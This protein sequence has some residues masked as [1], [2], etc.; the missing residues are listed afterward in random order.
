MFTPEWNASF[1]LGCEDQW[2]DDE[3]PFIIGNELPQGDY[4]GG[5][6]GGIGPLDI[7]DG[8][9]VA[10]QFSD[11]DGPGPKYT[12]EHERAFF[13]LSGL[14]RENA[15]VLAWQGIRDLA[16]TIGALDFDSSKA[17]SFG[18]FLLVYE[19]AFLI[20]YEQVFLLGGGLQ[21][22]S[23]VPSRQYDLI[24]ILVA[25]TDEPRA[26]TK[27]EGRRDRAKTKQTAKENWSKR[28]SQPLDGASEKKEDKPDSLCS[29]PLDQLAGCRVTLVNSCASCGIYQQPKNSFAPKHRD[30][31]R[32]V[33][34]QLIPQR[35]NFPAL[36]C[37]ASAGIDAEEARM[38]LTP[39]KE[40]RGNWSKRRRKQP[41]TRGHKKKEQKMPSALARSDPW[42]ITSLSG[43]WGE[44]FHSASQGILHPAEFFHVFALLAATE[45]LATPEFLHPSLPILP[46][47]APPNAFSLVNPF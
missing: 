14:P 28:R 37:S 44:E 32:P 25:G 24:G 13:D 8:P 5:V 12:Y 2:D 27:D 23:F 38:A 39:K 33:H 19:Q 11:E 16:F 1:T 34:F 20:V 42:P 3:L 9:S 35:I 30:L 4:Q 6:N 17:G 10:A 29:S 22:D 15:S 40:W 46:L 41:T 45:F 43:R 21:R 18:G 7:Q 47:H 36:F 26:E 31:F